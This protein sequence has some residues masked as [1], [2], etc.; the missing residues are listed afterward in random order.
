M[1]SSLICPD[2]FLFLAQFWD[3]HPQNWVQVLW[4]STLVYFLNQALLVGFDFFCVTSLGPG[5]RGTGSL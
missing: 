1:A 2:F 4:T 5:L 3:P